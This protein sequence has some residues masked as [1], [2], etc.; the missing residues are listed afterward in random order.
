[1]RSGDEYFRSANT[2]KSAG[3]DTGFIDKTR[4]LVLPFEFDTASSFVDGIARI[5]VDGKMGIHRQEGQLHL[6]TDQ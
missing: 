1:M 2:S 3:N 4:K 5:Y 6:E